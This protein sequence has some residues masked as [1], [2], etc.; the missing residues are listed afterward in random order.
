[1]MNELGYRWVSGGFA[2]ICL[3]LLLAGT[4]F[5]TGLSGVVTTPEG[6][7]IGDADVWV[8]QDHEVQHQKTG[9]SGKFAVK[10]LQVGPAELVAWKDGWSLGGH[11]GPLSADADI[12]VV[13]QRTGQIRLRIVSNTFFP[14]PGASVKTMLINDQL[15]VSPADLAPAGFAPIRAS[16]EGFLVIP[17]LPA[18]G[19]IKLVVGHPDYADSTVAYLPVR[20]E[21][22][23]IVLVPGIKLRGRVA[24]KG[25]GVAGARVAVRQVGAGSA[26]ETSDL[27]SDAEGYFS[28]KLTAGVYQVMASHRDYATQG[29]LSVT[30][31]EGQDPTVELSLETPRFLRGTVLGPDNHG[32]AG[33]QVVYRAG[34]MVSA[35]ALSQ[36][37][38]G[39]VLKVAGSEGTLTVLPPPGLMTAA[40]P[41][42]PVKLGEEQ[43]VKIEAIALKR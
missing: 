19:F 6:D 30:M 23:E 24:H 4:A 2:A 20:E 25:R 22:Q 15:L 33:V 42:V 16:D 14:V 32:L 34:E 31:V 10:D 21:Q 38:G 18:G 39:I 37:D 36:A 29:P 8:T 35:T 9:A 40:L 28:V 12:K 1:M 17:N 26:R 3:G 43:D 27:V 11:F 7:P 13:L 5:G 41:N